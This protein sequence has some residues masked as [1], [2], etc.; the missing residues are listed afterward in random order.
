VSAGLRAR[1]SFRKLAPCGQLLVSRYD[2]RG[3]L[4][5]TT[6]IGTSVLSPGS[7]DRVERRDG[8]V[9]LRTVPQ[10][11]WVLLPG[12]LLTEQDAAHLLD[13]R[14]V[15]LP[16]ALPA[17]A[18]PAGPGGLLAPG[19]RAT[20]TDGLDLIHVVDARARRDVQV[21]VA[22]HRLRSRNGKLLLASVVLVTGCATLVRDWVGLSMVG[23]AVL[24]AAVDV[25]R[26]V[27]AVGRSRPVGQLLHAAVTPTHLV[28]DDGDSESRL[29]W[30]SIRACTTTRGAVVLV[31]RQGVIVPLP[32]A[33]FPARDLARLQ[34]LVR[35]PR[36]PDGG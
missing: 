6:A 21:A 29:P 16:S 1:H 11:R 26:P 9:H 22:A 33:L 4:A 36:S 13:R 18:A 24:L 32:R 31:L 30:E 14:R 20:P 2:D 3:R 23:V 34:Q 17:A 28:V 7:V 8:L 15:A 5:L 19:D 12:Q 35:D 25:A 27:L 10:R